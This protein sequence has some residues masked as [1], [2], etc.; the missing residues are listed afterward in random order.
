M[1]GK[2]QTMREKLVEMLPD[3]HG[4]PEYATQDDWGDCNIQVDIPLDEMEVGQCV[5]VYWSGED[6]WFEGEITGVSV[7]DDQFEILYDSDKEQLWHNVSDY[8]VRMS[9]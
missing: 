1:T 3:E 9:C 4:V 8:S 7:K 5:E 6:A 2:V